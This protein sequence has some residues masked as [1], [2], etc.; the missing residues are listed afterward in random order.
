MATIDSL[1]I[2]IA[3]SVQKANRAI[4]S[5]ITNLGRLANSLKIDTSGLEKIGKSLNFSG[6]DKT[7]KNMQSQA[8]KVSKSMSQI[9][10]QYKDLG[11]GFEI[12]GSTQ[13]IQKQIDALTNKLANAKLAKDDFEASG[14]TNLGGYETAVKNVIKYTNQIESLKKQLEGLQTAQPKLDFNTTGI[15]EAGHKV[16]EVTEKIKT[17]TIP[18]SAFD[19]NADAMK[20]VFGEAA[21]GIENWSQATQKF[22]ANAGAVLNQA[23]SKTDELKARTEQFEQSLKNLQ[24]PPINTDNINVL[25]REL[26]KSEANFEKLRTKLANGIAMGR[27]SA[28]VDDKGFRNLREQ[29]ALAEKKGEALR[30][31]IKHVQQ[32]STQTSTGA[33][34][35]GDSVKSASKSF[36]GLASSS[37]KAIKP[38][39]NLGNSFRSLLRV[40]L[41]ILGIRQLFNWGKQSMQVASDL[42]EIQNVTDTTFANMSYKVEDFAKTSIEQ[43][44]LSELALK[45]YSSRFQSMGV[46]MGIGAPLIG[47]ANSNLSKLTDG[48][49]EASDSMADVSLNLTKLT[50]DMASFYNV[51]Q[52]VVAEKLAS[53]FTGKTRPLRDFGLDLTQATLQEWALKQGMDANMQSMSQAEKTMLRYQYIM[54]NTAAVHNDFSRTSGSWANQVR[55]LSQNFQQLAGIVGGVLVNAFKPVISAANAAMS[56]I[57]AFAKVISNALGKIFGWTYEEGGGGIAQDFGGAAEAA[58]DLA[59]STGKA[60]KNIKEMKAGLRAFDELKTISMPDSDSGGGGGG[61]GGGGAGGAGEDGGQWVKGESILKQFESDIDSLYDLGKYIGQKL[62][63]AMNRIDWESVYEKARNFGTE[64][65]NFLNGLISPELFGAVGTTIAGALNTALHFL[66]SFGT[67]FDWENFGN[68]IAAGINDFFDTFD[69]ELLA[70]TLN[71][72][73]NGL[74][75][76]IITYLRKVEWEDIGTKI[77]EFLEKINF[78]QIGKKM[79]IALWEAL[80]AGIEFYKGMFT[81]APIETAIITILTATKTLSK[82]KPAAKLLS[83]NVMGILSKSLTSATGQIKIGFSTGNPFGGLINASKS[84]VKTIQSELSQLST[85]MKLSI[86]AATM[87]GEFALIR[88]G[89]SDLISG[90]DSFG[91]LV[92]SIGEIGVA[93]V[94]AKTIL[95]GVFG[96][97]GPIVAAITGV[98]AAF[99]GINAAMQEMAD[100]SAIGQFSTAL[101]EL[102]DSVSRETDSIKERLDKTKEDIESAGAAEAAMARD[103]AEEYSELSQKAGLSA[104]EKER[105]KTV[106]SSLAEIIPGLKGY[107]DDETG[108]LNIQKETLDKLIAGYESLAKKKAAQEALVDAY[109]AQYDA[110]MNVKH[111]QDGY[112]EAFDKYLSNAGIAPAIIDDIANGQL[113]LNQALVDFENSPKEFLQKYGVK[114][115]GTL[116]KA[117]NGLNEEMESYSK[118]LSDAQET[119]KKAGENVE[120][121]NGVIEDNEKKIRQMTEAEL[122]NKKATAGF[123][124]SVSNLKTEFSGFGASI[125]QEFAE[126]LALDE[127]D[128]GNMAET[129]KAAF[130]KMKNQ[131]QLSSGELKTLFR[132]FGVEMS[133]EFIQALSQKEPEVQASVTAIFADMSAVVKPSIDDLKKVFSAI[134]TE[135]PDE[136]IKGLSGKDAYIQQSIINTLSNLKI[137]MKLTEPSL[138]QLFSE[139]GW[140]VP[141]ELIKSIASEDVNVQGAAIETLGALQTAAE[142]KG[143]EI[144]DLYNA[145]GSETINQLINSI[146]GL[147]EETKKTALDLIGQLMVAADDQREPIISKLKELGIEFDESFISGI[148]DSTEK[149]RIDKAGKDLPE[150]AYNGANSA[151]KINEMAEIGK[152]MLR[153]FLNGLSDSELM[154]QV[155]S[156]ANAMAD[157]A[158]NAAQKRLDEHSPSKVFEKIGKFTVEGYNAG[159]KRNVGET[160]SIVNDWFKGVSSYKVPEFKAYK[161]ANLIPKMDFSENKPLGAEIGDMSTSLQADINATMASRENELRQQ[162]QLLREQNELL[163]MI[164]EK[165]ALSDDAVFNSA[166]RGQQKYQSRTWKTGWAGVD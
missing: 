90:P 47:Q 135:L 35:L 59:G 149:A 153:G 5:L 123:Q 161:P 155:V 19:Y 65:A 146:S 100:N 88:N 81:A 85:G 12:K 128:G 3:G 13:Q 101:G 137:G 48:Y 62:T 53:V 116:R 29:M 17:A 66:D 45:Q 79:G 75:D 6:I 160:Y 139:L 141:D 32:A 11:K 71:T 31:K 99:A 115:Y 136:V 108:V 122:A 42:T 111:A 44:G 33:K 72:W 41:P 95:T 147:S 83:D 54:A 23:T 21:A 157:A 76:T 91:A 67:D 140:K 16:S 125:S 145:F 97:A 114:D 38:L 166:R 64:L 144:K 40:I 63:E 164:Y 86:G 105:L 14:K 127:M 25:Q 89:I 46:T 120:Y 98:A 87:V 80:N 84:A 163:R 96:A 68:S 103:L 121:L 148:S 58:D 151:N 77:G 118:T 130:E 27:I 56:A 74:L 152:N 109:K 10:E 126:I 26:A 24:T 162:N 61:G 78:I 18:Q 50:A 94:A 39:N 154:G 82:I 73:A 119:E 15:E 9:T 158:K 22:G 70:N 20:A 52:D 112:N 104:D 107:I 49:I 92:V 1:D 37:T 113:D 142:E 8:K 117:V 34:K 30:E 131:T 150:T 156:Q 28:N 102:S 69:F 132:T 106:S 60:A 93:A 143:V 159:I 134:G 110:Q 43:F 36:A 124:Q 7:A 138:L 133:N 4:D 2:Q 57:I 51:E 165:P 129:I 55:I